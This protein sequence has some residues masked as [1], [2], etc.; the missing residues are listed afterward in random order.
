MV[1]TPTQREPLDTTTL[2]LLLTSGEET[3][4]GLMHRIRANP[5][6]RVKHHHFPKRASRNGRAPKATAPSA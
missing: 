4:S 1:D 3:E 6:P 5:L 2:R